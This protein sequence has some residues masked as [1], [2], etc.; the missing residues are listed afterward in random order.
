MKKL[1][2]SF[3]V[4]FSVFCFGQ[5]GREK[6][7]QVKWV[8]ERENTEYRLWRAYFG[9][10]QEVIKVYGKHTGRLTFTSF[11][12]GK[13]V[14]NGSFSSEEEAVSALTNYERKKLQV[15][16]DKVAGCLRIAFNRNSSKPQS[17]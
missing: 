8:L 12:N 7:E 17:R 10:S 14:G 15:V 4:L 9:Q 1:V 13:Q 16:P 2:L 11:V 5:P 6:R 3:F